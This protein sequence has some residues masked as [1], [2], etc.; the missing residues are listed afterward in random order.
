MSLKSAVF[1]I[2]FWV[3]ELKIDEVVGTSRKLEGDGKFAQNQK[4]S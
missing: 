1:T 3:N 2:Y 4:C